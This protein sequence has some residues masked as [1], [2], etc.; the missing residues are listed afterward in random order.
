M[1]ELT[2]KLLADNY[3][4]AFFTFYLVIPFYS[5]QISNLP[6][7]LLIIV[8]AMSLYFVAAFQIYQQFSTKRHFIMDSAF[9]LTGLLILYLLEIF[10]F[11]NSTGHQLMVYMLLSISYLPTAFRFEAIKKMS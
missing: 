2:L 5:K 4:I 10:V 9:M 1:S 3:G 8:V 11:V 6:L 7:L